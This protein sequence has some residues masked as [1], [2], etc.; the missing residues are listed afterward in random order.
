M[1]DAGDVIMV[2][3]SRGTRMERVVEALRGAGPG[4]PADAP[5]EEY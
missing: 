3:G 1:A 5:E 2:K 4:R